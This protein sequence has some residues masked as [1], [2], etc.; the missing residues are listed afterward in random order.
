MVADVCPGEHQAEE[1]TRPRV[2]YRRPE[3]RSGVKTQVRTNEI[4]PRHKFS[5]PAPTP[6]KTKREKLLA[7]WLCTVTPSGD[8]L[9]LHHVQGRMSATRRR[10]QVRVKSLNWEGAKLPVSLFICV[11]MGPHLAP[12]LPLAPPP[13]TGA[14]RW[15]SDCPPLTENPPR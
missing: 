2:E 5:N 4:Q 12:P 7:L 9:E 6:R 11:H 13:A 15:R 1:K 3:A 10:R 14:P 8:S